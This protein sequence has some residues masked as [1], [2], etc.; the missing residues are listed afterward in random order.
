[1]MFSVLFFAHRARSAQRCP[2]N[3]F[4]RIPL[5]RSQQGPNIFLKIILSDSIADC[6]SVFYALSVF[7]FRASLVGLCFTRTNRKISTV[8][9]FQCRWQF[10]FAQIIVII[11]SHTFLNH[12]EKHFG[13]QNVF[14]NT[15][16]I[17]K[18]PLE[19]IILIA[20]S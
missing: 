10:T 14:L 1:M 13:P 9:V 18:I 6:F 11:E 15:M 16:E 17:N 2:L 4:F 20:G 19:Y 12:I 3:R 8:L 5:S 7:R